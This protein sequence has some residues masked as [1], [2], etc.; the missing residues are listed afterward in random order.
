M[1]MLV[2]APFDVVGADPLV[3]LMPYVKLKAL[4]N[5]FCNR[6]NRCNHLAVATLVYSQ[7]LLW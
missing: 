5:A 3:I 6:C 1:Q 4:P 7:H 2:L